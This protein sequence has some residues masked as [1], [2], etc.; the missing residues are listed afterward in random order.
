MNLLK[1]ALAH[2]SSQIKPP[3]VILRAIDK[4][5]KIKDDNQSIHNGVTNEQNSESSLRSATEPVQKRKRGRPAK[6]LN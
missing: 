5:H 1:K 3:E 6:R 2:L 4:P